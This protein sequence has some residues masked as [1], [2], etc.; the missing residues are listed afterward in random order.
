[1]RLLVLGGTAFV[2][3]MIADYALSQGHDV[4]LFNRGKTN[5]DSFPNAEHLTGDRDGD[6]KTLEGHTWDVVIDTCGYLPRIVELSASLLKDAV[7]HYTFI[8]TISVY[9]DLESTVGIDEDSPLGT[10]EDETNEEITGETYGPLKAL[11]ENMVRKYFPDN[12]LIVRPGLIVG[13]W[14][15]TYRFSYWLQRT[16]EG[17]EMLAPGDPEQPMQ[18][19]D[20]RDLAKFTVDMAVAGEVG[21]YLA[22][23]PADPLPL[24]TILETARKITQADTKFTWVDERFL[25]ENEIAPWVELPLWIPST[26]SAIHKINVS[27]SINAGLTFRPLEETFRDNLVWLKEQAKQKD[28]SQQ[29]ARG[30]MTRERETEL[31]QKWHD[32]ALA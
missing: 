18:V 12:H 21:N 6:L 13:P 25:I 24:K 27:K 7:K 3:R 8:S 1:M 31:L 9:K 16:E 20:A 14:D 17:G 22:T 15:Y 10:M 32:Q 28:A 26:A 5:P 19:I 30:A 2:G 23:G 4:T 29:L 11:C